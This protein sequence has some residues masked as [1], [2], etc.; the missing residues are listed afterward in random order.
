MKYGCD[1]PLN[2]RANR[3]SNKENVFVVFERRIRFGLDWWPHL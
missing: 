2:A 1:A 3:C